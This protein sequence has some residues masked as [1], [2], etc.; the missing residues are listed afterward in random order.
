MDV[1]SSRFIVQPSDLERSCR[2]Y[3]DTLGL[4]VYREFGAPDHPGMVFFLA[5]LNS[6][7]QFWCHTEIIGPIRWLDPWLNTPQNH[8][9]H[10]ARARAIADGNYGSNL[11]LWDRLFGTYRTGPR[12]LE[13]GVEGQRD[14]LNPLRLQFGSLWHWLA[15]R[16]K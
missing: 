9:L 13:F 7:T 16:A 14:S 11:M 5:E 12:V 1:L 8:R 15:P 4:A 2:F 10:H 3:R 6:A